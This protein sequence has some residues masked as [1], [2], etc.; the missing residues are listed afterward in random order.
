M[1]GEYSKS[2]VGTVGVAMVV[3]K[4]S[5]DDEEGVMYYKCYGGSQDREGG[6]QTSIETF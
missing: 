1:V 4:Q 6:H 3:N 5:L 2:G